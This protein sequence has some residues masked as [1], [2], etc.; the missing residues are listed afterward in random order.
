MKKSVSLLLSL[1]MLC[2]LLVITPAA[3]EGL[4][5]VAPSPT[6]PSEYTT[7][8]T[9]EE[10]A[11]E[12]SPGA[13]ANE[14][15]AEPDHWNRSLVA[16]GTE[17][18]YEDFPMQIDK[19]I[20]NDANLTLLFYYMKNIGENDSVSLTITDLQTETAVVSKSLS[21]GNTAVQ[22]RNV[23]NNKTFSVTLLETLDNQT[24]QYDAAIETSYV[25]ALFPSGIAIG[26]TTTPDVGAGNA[27]SIMV[28]R[29]GTPPA[30]ATEEELATYQVNVI[31]QNQFGSFYQNLLPNQIYTAQV[32]NENAGSYDNNIG[33][34]STYPGGDALGIYT[35]AYSFY[36]VA[37]NTIPNT[38]NSN[39]YYSAIS[40]AQIAALS[41]WNLDEAEN[42]VGFGNEMVTLSTSNPYVIVKWTAPQIDPFFDKVNFT[43]ETAGNVDTVITM[44]DGNG[45]ATDVFNDGGI[46]GNVV[47]HIG[48]ELTF[49]GGQV[50][51]FVLRRHSGSYGTFL[52][53]I[54]RTN[55][56]VTVDDDDTNFYDEAQTQIEAGN[57]SP[58]DVLLE[59]SIDYEG[60]YD[61]FVIDSFPYKKYRVDVPDSEIDIQITRYSSDLTPNAAGY[62]TL[63]KEF[64]FVRGEVTTDAHP[65]TLIDYA[66]AYSEDRTY[67]RVSAYNYGTKEKNSFYTY[68]MELMTPYRK[69]EYDLTAEDGNDTTGT[70]TELDFTNTTFLGIDATIHL[71]DYDYYQF[72][73][74]ADGGSFTAK[75]QQMGAEYFYDVNIVESDYNYVAVGSLNTTTGLKVAAAA[76]LQPYT[77]YYVEV[78]SQ[79]PN[80]EYDAINPYY[81]A[82]TNQTGTIYSAT[83]SEDITVSYETGSLT[84]NALL[85]QIMPKLTCKKANAIIPSE[86]AR[87][88]IKL[89]YYKSGMMKTELTDANAST[90]E[91]GSYQI[92]VTYKDASASGAVISLTI[93]DAQLNTTWQNAEEISVGTDNIFTISGPPASASSA[94]WWYK[95]NLSSSGLYALT[96]N[97]SSEDISAVIYVSSSS[98]AP[99]EHYSY[100]KPVYQLT[101]GTYYIKVEIPTYPGSNPTYSYTFSSAVGTGNTPLDTAQ[102]IIFTNG[103]SQTDFV[104]GWYKLDANKTGEYQFSFTTDVEGVLLDLY[105]YEYSNG[106]FIDRSWFSISQDDSRILPGNTL[107]YMFPAGNGPM[108][109]I[110]TEPS[111]PPWQNAQTLSFST[112]NTIDSKGSYIYENNDGQWFEIT[113]PASGN[114]VLWYDTTTV[115]ELNLYHLDEGGLTHQSDFLYYT[116]KGIPLSQGDSYYLNLTTSGENCEYQIRIFPC[117]TEVDAADVRPANFI[118]GKFTANG[119][120]TSWVFLDAANPGTYTCEFNTT[121]PYYFYQIY[122][123]KYTNGVLDTIQ[124]WYQP[125]NETEIVLDGGAIYYIYI[126]DGD[127][128]FSLTFQEPP[129][130]SW[131]AAHEITL[132]TESWLDIPVPE[133]IYTYESVWYKFTAPASGTYQFYIG[134]N[135]QIIELYQKSG[136]APEYIGY[137]NYSYG[138]SSSLISGTTYYVKI[139]DNQ[140][141]YIPETGYTARIIYTPNSTAQ[142]AKEMILSY[143]ET[144]SATGSFNNGELWYKFQ[145]GRASAYE[146]VSPDNTDFS[147]ELY[148]QYPGQE[149]QLVTPNYFGHYELTTANSVIYY[150]KI[151]SNCGGLLYYPECEFTFRP[152]YGSSSSTF[153]SSPELSSTYEQLVDGVWYRVNATSVGDYSLNFQIASGNL[154]DIFIYEYALDG[155]FIRSYTNFTRGDGNQDIL[156]GQRIY[157]VKTD[158]VDSSMYMSVTE[159]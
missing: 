110:I 98:G 126:F 125:D 147:Y 157:F 75:L 20:D 103:A 122:F 159:P 35:P 51:Y 148:L 153:Y 55:T 131:Q 50:R 3:E 31:E 99:Y 97:N 136:D 59:R 65:D 111:A 141:I 9:D 79:N 86:A 5:N 114:Y 107:Y 64:D 121:N 108:T 41:D 158:W 62:D 27:P 47:A 48:T 105:V 150:L 6:A 54:R 32:P 137:S 73:T 60:D 115:S 106:V 37:V 145:I 149:L 7:P 19:Q 18:I 78:C 104:D 45:N 87:P 68:D 88:D 93:S 13:A 11:P 140:S 83:L 63:W 146:I 128:D 94:E 92:F 152:L 133:N 84:R 155:T 156:S 77:T 76:N 2:S 10:P 139:F 34:I 57:P 134:N 91:P 85:D 143:E 74:G 138:F 154:A 4:E 15:A 16:E 90:L 101:P 53:R 30:G 39:M 17:S 113:P 23:P 66:A 71:D 58:A 96:S 21:S 29:A 112:Q 22:F 95:F 116:S 56:G 69:D 135:N 100:I 72:T 33:F 24:T 124:F 123:K 127:N 118:K 119:T 81:L 25:P 61:W 42:Y 132:N 44:L 40:G 36:L 1:V 26:N 120:N 109:A 89:E 130:T 8:P 144:L 142:T 38:L 67:F 129:N 117:A 28:R 43:V 52:F 102:D 82:L 14:T 12:T 80:S 151:S 70:A 49:S 46:G